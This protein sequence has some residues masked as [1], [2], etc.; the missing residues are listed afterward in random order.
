MSWAMWQIWCENDQYEWKHHTLRLYIS[1]RNVPIN[2]I[3]SVPCLKLIPLHPVKIL[4]SEKISKKSCSCVEGI[5]MVFLNQILFKHYEN[6]G[7][8]YILYYLDVHQNELKSIQPVLLNPGA[9]LL[10]VALSTLTSPFPQIIMVQGGH[11]RHI[12]EPVKRIF[13]TMSSSNIL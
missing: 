2:M 8:W 6:L 7:I 4:S 3:Q 10:F 12:P 5:I 1:T 13:V 11:Q 9:L